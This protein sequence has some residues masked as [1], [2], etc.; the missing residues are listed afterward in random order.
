MA[1]TYCYANKF[2]PHAWG[3]SAASDRH[4]TTLYVFPTRVGMFRGG[5]DARLMDDGFPHT[6]GDVPGRRPKAVHIRA[7]SPHAWGCSERRRVRRVP[8]VVFPTRVGMFRKP[9][10]SPPRRKSFPHTRGDVPTVFGLTSIAH[11]FS[12]HAWGCS[13]CRRPDRR[14]GEVFPTRVGMFRAIPTRSSRR[15]CFPHTRGD[16]PE[17]L[18][19]PPG[20]RRFSPHAW[21]C[22]AGTAYRARIADVFPTR[23]GM[24]RP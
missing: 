6:R 13:A 3:C 19:M 15:W 20:A 1:C 12:P 24:F 22:S 14:T 18:I 16:V 9:H 17:E 8:R 23:V 10:G 5:S 11:L 21:G 7:F 4:H 2:S